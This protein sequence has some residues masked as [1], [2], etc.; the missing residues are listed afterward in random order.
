MKT[1]ITSRDPKGQQATAIFEAV[2]NKTKFNDAAAQ[3]LNESKHF[4]T[5][6]F[7]L[8]RKCS[9]KSSGYTLMRSIL[10]DDLITP[11]EIATARHDIVYSAEQT[12]KLMDSIPSADTLNWC[13]ANGYAVVAGPPR[14]MSLLD[15]QISKIDHFSK[16]GTWYADADEKFA[17]DDKVSLGWLAVCKTPIPKS[18]GN[19]WDEQNR[20]LLGTERVS[21][22][23]KLSWFITVF[24]DV[25]GVR[26]FD[27]IYA[28]TFSLG[29]NGHRVYVGQFGDMGLYVTSGW[30]GKRNSGIGLVATRKI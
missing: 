30:D 10:G 12:A 27:R 24:Y 4:A 13:K 23:A 22:A 7:E 1:L 3:R 21:N 15:I 5:G 29:S 19:T 16:Y 6:L 2:Y 20:L 18:M 8:F 26:L 28:R 11:E 14:P 17:R 25:R 9:A